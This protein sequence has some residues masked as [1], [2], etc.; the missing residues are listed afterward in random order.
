MGAIYCGPYAA[1]IGYDRHEVLGDLLD[2]IA[3]RA[4]RHRRRRS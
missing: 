3:D 2:E 4:T 1:A